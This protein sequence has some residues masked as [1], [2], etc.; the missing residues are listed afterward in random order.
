MLHSRIKRV[1]NLIRDQIA[2]IL[3][4]ELQDPRFRFITVSSVRVTRDLQHAIVFVSML[5]EDETKV[6][7]T[8]EALARAKGSI[9]R[10]LSSRIVLKF[11][12]DITFEL[13]TSLRRVARINQILHQIHNEEP[14]D[15]E[16]NSPK[17][18]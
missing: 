17:S 9:K 14:P 10:L 1:E 16:S 4:L 8:L 6:H 7:N 5:E 2:Q 12:P 15:S 11:M 3:L 18:D 13:D